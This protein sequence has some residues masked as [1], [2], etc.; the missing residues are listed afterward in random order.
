MLVL[1]GAV[2]GCGDFMDAP[3]TEVALPDQ[4]QHAEAEH[5]A[6]PPA[7]LARDWYKTA[8]DKPLDALIGRI[9]KQN[10]SI[11]QARFRLQ[12][13]RATIGGWKYLPTLSL[14]QTT[15]LEPYYSPDPYKFTP[16]TKLGG[17]F[18]AGLDASW[19]IP[20][21]GTYGAAEDQAKANDVF[22]QADIEAVHNAVI[23]EA[24]TDYV[25]LRAAQTRADLLT[26]IL[27]RQRHIVAL[28]TLKTKNG[29][30]ADSDR[31]KAEQAE[32]TAQSDLA[33]AQNSI[34][35]YQQRLAKLE[36]TTT[37]DASLTQPGPV[38]QF[39]TLNI[40][41][42][43]LDVLRNR[44][45]IR[46]A[47]QSVLLAASDLT[48]AKADRYPQLSLQGSLMKPFNI[49]G[50]PVLDQRPSPSLTETV[51]M[52]LFDWG[53]KLATAQQKDAKLAEQASAY[54]ETVVGA[55]TE[56]QQRFA[57]Y[58]AAHTQQRTT[59]ANAQK[60]ET[61]ASQ[62][63]TLTTS[64]LSD[65]IV[66]ESAYIDLAQARIASANATAT[67]GE[68]LANLTNAL[69][70]GITS[71]PATTTGDVREEKK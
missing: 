58:T 29:L 24:V 28:T 14:Q 15:Q 68:N 52:P 27:Q 3:S 54:R 71:P 10:L 30:A 42:R 59:H 25:T 64:G 50:Q 48:L 11:E 34:A 43:P 9:E 38:P 39:P 17:I 26:D 12:A 44:P 63:A 65:D 70:G 20:L 47:E 45:D 1:A 23:A 56:T 57:S 61:L 41:D 67:E 36:G 55:I 2:A 35:E 33:A 22:A 40:S 21:F 62:A 18:Q 13:A 49:I 6:Q 69:G 16:Q 7:P 8:Q 53:Q 60:A 5:A 31:L 51:T 32:Q 37:V 46:K 66:R 19:E 4:F